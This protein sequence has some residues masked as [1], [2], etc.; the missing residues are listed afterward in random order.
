[1]VK[2]DHLHMIRQMSYFMRENILYEVKI[3]NLDRLIIHKEL[4]F[5][6]KKLNNFLNDHM[7]LNINR[8]CLFI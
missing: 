4:R 7:I 8:S 6:V 3:L 1:M 5:N 2:I